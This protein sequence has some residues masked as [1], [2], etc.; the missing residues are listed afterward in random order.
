MSSGQPFTVN[1]IFDVNLDGN[2][3]DRLNTTNGLVNT[4]NRQQP[5]LL[6]VPPVTLLAPVGSDGAVTRNTF[7]AGGVVELDIAGVKRVAISGGQV[8]HFRVEI[9]NLLN[10]ANFAIPV[11][12]LEAP[13]FGQATST[14]TPGRR[15]QFSL[16]F[17]F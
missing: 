13:A 17:L 4:G 11:R 15:V 5:L 16:K 7:R 6:T 8:L 2:L 12:Y 10:R 9:F 1:S 14:I 3:T